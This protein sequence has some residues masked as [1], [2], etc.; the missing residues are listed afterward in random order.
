[1]NL[2]NRICPKCKAVV[3]A[4]GIT[5]QCICGA[6]VSA[7]G[8]LPDDG[9]DADA[10]G[11]AMQLRKAEAAITSSNTTI[12]PKTAQLQFFGPQPTALIIKPAN[13]LVTD[14][15]SYSTEST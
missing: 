9:P 8:T 14:P 6:I 2:M 1:M 5:V 4:V 11:Y 13:S 3:L 10:I 7:H 12:T 15:S